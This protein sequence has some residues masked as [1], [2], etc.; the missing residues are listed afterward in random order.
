MSEQLYEISR[1]LG[2][3]AQ[4]SIAAMYLDRLP[5]RHRIAEIDDEAARSISRWVHE[6]DCRDCDTFLDPLVETYFDQE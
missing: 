6:E 4:V 1:D 3:D 2:D 5:Q